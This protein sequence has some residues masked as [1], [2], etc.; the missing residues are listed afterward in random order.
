MVPLRR[1]ITAAVSLVGHG[2]TQDREKEDPW[3]REQ[4]E[5]S[6]D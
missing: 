3:Q 6:Y 2:L 1:P 5:Q 4:N